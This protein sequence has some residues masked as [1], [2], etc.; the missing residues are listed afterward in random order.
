MDQVTIK[1][2]ALGMPR[3]SQ[4]SREAMTIDEVDQAIKRTLEA[5][6]SGKLRPEELSLEAANL[7]KWKET[8]EA[9]AVAKGEKIKPGMKPAPAKPQARPPQAPAGAEDLG[10]EPN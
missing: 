7:R 1:R 5:A 10:G 8:L 4:V 6:K 3:F 9:E 2:K